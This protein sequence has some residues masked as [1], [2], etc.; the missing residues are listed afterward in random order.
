MG[1]EGTVFAWT[2][3]GDRYSE[4]A[5]IQPITFQNTLKN[6]KKFQISASQKDN[7]HTFSQLP[8][9]TTA[10]SAELAKPTPHRPTQKI[11]S[12]PFVLAEYVN[13]F[14]KWR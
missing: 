5:Y 10:Q 2:F 12:P 11:S 6:K 13:Y 1:I 4:T 3:R 14:N 7:A 8:H 9:P